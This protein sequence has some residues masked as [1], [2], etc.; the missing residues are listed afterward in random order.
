MSVCVYVYVCVCVC[1]GRRCLFRWL[2]QIALSVLI[3]PCKL[4]LP[5]KMH[6][7]RVLCAGFGAVPFNYPQLNCTF[8]SCPQVPRPKM[9]HSDGCDKTEVLSAPR[10]RLP[11][12]CRFF[13]FNLAAT[14]EILRLITVARLRHKVTKQTPRGE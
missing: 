12:P 9:L 5:E 8:R 11:S 7:K 10:M 4:D 2:P 13:I 1:V 3:S 14:I 6:C